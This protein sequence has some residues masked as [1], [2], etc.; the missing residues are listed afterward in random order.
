MKI[1]TIVLMLALSALGVSEASAHVAIEL[2]GSPASMERQ[3]RV[4]VDAGFTFVQ[5]PEQIEQLIEEGTLVRLPGNDYYDVLDG[6][7]SDAAL[8]ETKLFIERLA[9]QYFEATGEKLVVTSLTRPSSMQPSNSHS[10]SVH[11]T[12]AA[13]DFRV[14]QRAESR[15]WL[16][17]ALLALEG[18][19]VLDVTRERR[20]PH[21]HVALFPEAYR[22]YIEDLI[23]PDQVAVALGEVEPEAMPV[24]ALAAT[25]TLDNDTE[26]Q[27]RRT[28]WG[29]LRSIFFG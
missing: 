28:F 27:P 3:N 1:R 16:E 17:N 6:L 4:A 19:G 14:S 29:W 10:L 7:V 11:P 12:G 15:Q 22:T 24:A 9:E 5:T 20:P 26:P 23:G 21:Y 13:I 8:P 18:N 2:K 25:A